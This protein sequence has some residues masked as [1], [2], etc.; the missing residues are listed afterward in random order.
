MKVSKQTLNIRAIKFGLVTAALVTSL[1]TLADVSV[2]VL[3][4]NKGQPGAG[5]NVRF[6]QQLDGDWQLL[7]QQTTNKQGRINSFELGK[8]AYYRVVFD[9]APFFEQQHIDTFYSEIPVE[10]KVDDEN[11]H[12]HIPLLL[13]PYAYSTYRG[14]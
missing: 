3:D 10:F 7:S 6:Y 14:N 9:V 2:H 8:G 4:T 11:A 13:S 1:P 12:Y 5:V